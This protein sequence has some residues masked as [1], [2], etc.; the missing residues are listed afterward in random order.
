MKKKRVLWEKMYLN[1]KLFTIDPDVCNKHNY[2]YGT[3][4]IM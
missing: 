1:W 4:I 3:Y 2:Y